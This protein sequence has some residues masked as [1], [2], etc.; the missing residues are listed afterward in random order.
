MRMIYV[1]EEV[2]HWQFLA[3]HIQLTLTV[4]AMVDE[5]LFVSIQNLFR[6]HPSIQTTRTLHL[7]SGGW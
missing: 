6:L 1:L 2:L 4:E 5:A 3:R 7:H